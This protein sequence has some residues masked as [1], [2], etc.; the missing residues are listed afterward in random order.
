MW[1]EQLI[2]NSFWFKDH[3][4]C[5]L[6]L[7]N[8]GHSPASAYACQML[9]C[10]FTVQGVHKTARDG[11][12]V[13]RIQQNRALLPRQVVSRITLFNNFVF[14]GDACHGLD[15]SSDSHVAA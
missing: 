7:P 4:S 12:R 1:F 13:S 15:T 6:C 3:G 14:R 8:A 10:E 2:S 5:G 11:S 9:G